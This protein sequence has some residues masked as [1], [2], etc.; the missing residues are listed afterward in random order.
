MSNSKKEGMTR[1]KKRERKK[2]GIERV[3]NSMKKY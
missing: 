3:R 1:N 2:K